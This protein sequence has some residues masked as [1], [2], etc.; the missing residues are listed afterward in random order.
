MKLADID[1]VEST[2]RA[3]PR[4]KAPGPDGLTYETYSTLFNSVNE[5]S[6]ENLKALTELI[7]SS[8]STSNFPSSASNGVT[9]LLPKDRIFLGN[10]SRIRPITLHDSYRKIMEAILNKRLNKILREYGMLKGLH[11]GFKRGAGTSDAISIKR[12][13]N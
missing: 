8:F 12:V 3:L 5:E 10:M 1:E 2:I 13:L 6:L 11:Y 4:D 7:N 9:I